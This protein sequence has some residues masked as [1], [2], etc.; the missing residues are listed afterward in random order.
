[1]LKRHTPLKAKKRLASRAKLR[2]RRRA[3][4]R[5]D[6]NRFESLPIGKGDAIRRVDEAVLE[7]ARRR[8]RCEWCGRPSRGRLDPAH[9]RSRGAGGHDTDENVAGLCRPCHDNHHAG[10][11]PTPDELRKV[12]ARRRPTHEPQQPQQP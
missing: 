4:D 9:V 12:I 10:H 3:R 2:P 11:S 6:P 5:L 7:R 8:P 1:M